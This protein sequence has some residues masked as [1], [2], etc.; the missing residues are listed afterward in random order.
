VYRALA[1]AVLLLHFATVL[2]V[3][4]GL[5][6]I[7]VGNLRGWRWVNTR[8]FRYAHL[9]A[10]AVVVLQAWLGVVCPLT[11]LESW[12]RLQAGEAGYAAGFIEHWVHRLLFYEAPAGVFTALYSGF[13]A[14][15]GLAWWRFP[16]R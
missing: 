4:A 16:P 9:G 6:A 10:I 3:V 2:F 8:V 11:T 7:L 15:V 1:D 14:M 13:A 5:P 12:L